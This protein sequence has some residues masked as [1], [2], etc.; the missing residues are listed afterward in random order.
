M[1][2]KVRDKGYAIVHLLPVNYKTKVNYPIFCN[3]RTAHLYFTDS[4]SQ[5]L[6]TR[7][8]TLD[9]RVNN[10]PKVIKQ[11]FKKIPSSTPSS[12]HKKCTEWEEIKIS[13]GS[14]VSD[15]GRA[16]NGGGG[17]SSMH[18]NYILVPAPFLHHEH[19]T[20]T[21]FLQTSQH[22]LCLSHG[23][24]SWNICIVWS[25]FKSSWAMEKFCT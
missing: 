11:K 4:V 17:G 6:F 19:W 16:E 9:F 21:G 7:R 12:V 23:V 13:W 14:S 2:K 3:Q 15:S 1:Q 24:G 20:N 8:R 10:K 18:H 5:E 22:I 25:W